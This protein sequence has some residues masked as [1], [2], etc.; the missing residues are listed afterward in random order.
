MN[1]SKEMS[2]RQVRREKMRREAA[3]TRLI[4]IG[5]I[6]LG[7]VLVAFFLI[8]PN[9][10]PVGE[11]TTITPQEYPL[12]DKNS[13]GKADAPVSV[14]VWE[15]FQCPACRNFS[16][17]TKPLLVENYI[18]KGLVRL[19]Y[20]FYPFIDDNSASKESDHS[21]NAAMCAA[22][23]GRFW[24]MHDI[25]FANWNGEN[26]GA[27][28]DRRLL[29]FAE[30]LGLDMD[31]FQSCFNDDK[32]ADLIQQDM[33]DGLAL[34]ITSTPTILVDGKL[35]TNPAGANYVPGYEDIAAA[36]DAALATK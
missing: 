16:D 13:M 3:R 34:G 15:D 11:I 28:A 9:L 7:A 17:D 29:A 30:A 21:A 22:D 23:Q 33:Q 20:H 10:K 31:A 32:Y 25:I 27:F 8:Y 24:D 4:S 1:K 35:V 5:L 36:I 26:Q 19:T 2:K 6:V 12:V 18:S 14:D